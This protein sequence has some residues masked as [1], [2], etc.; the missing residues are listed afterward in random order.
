MS[1]VITSYVL[2]VLTAAG[3]IAGYART[4]SIPSIAAGCTVG[5]LYGFGA[6]RQQHNA[7]GGVELSLIASVVLGGASIPRALR[8]RK[9]VPMMLS[10]LATI[11]MIT[12]GKAY[13][14]KA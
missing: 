7:P 9:P 3:G 1:L 13:S 14:E 4:K 6:Y 12:F 2:S 5:A 8:L 10:V 11:G